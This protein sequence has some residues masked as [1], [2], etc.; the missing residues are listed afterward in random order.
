MLTLVFLA[1]AIAAGDWPNYGRDPGGSRFSPLDQIH[2]GNVQKLR[3]AWRFRHGDIY[4]GGPGRRSSL[5]QST[6]LFVDHRLFVTSPFGRVFALD[7]ETGKQLWVFDPE[8]DVAAGYGDFAN[9]GV[10]TWLDPE[11]RKG[12]PCKRRI[13]VATIDAR[14]FALDS[15]TGKPCA[16]F[17]QKGSIDLRTGLRNPSQKKSEYEQTSPPV[18]VGDVVVVGS[19]IADNTRIDLPSGEVRGFSARTGE[20]LWTWHSIPQSKDDP[21]YPEWEPES[22]KK[23]GG[24]NAW[25]IFTADPERG[26]VFVPT[27]SA[28]PDYFGGTR[29][30]DNRYANSVV[31]L[32]A[33]DGKMV[34]HFQTVHHDL[35][36]YDVASPPALFTLKKDGKSIPA[37]AVGSKTG[38]LFLLDRTTGAPVFPVEERKVPASDVPGE[39][40]SPTQPFPSMPKPLVP[41]SLRPDE[42]W[43]ATEEDRKWCAEQVSKR[44]S[45]GIFTPPSLRG[46]VIV[47][48]NIG[49]MAWGG[50][51]IDKRNGLLIVPTNRLAAVVRLIPR[52]RAEQARSE[53]RDAEFAPQHGTPYAMQRKFLRSPSGAP[54]NAPP[55]GTL[56]ALDANTGEK[57]WEV[58]LG[59]MPQAAAIPGAEKFGSPSLGG[60][61][62]TAG[63]LVFIGASFDPH[64]RAFDVKTGK[65]LWRG[66]LPA[67]A[68]A[69]PMTYRTKSGKQFVAIA[70]GGHGLPGTNPGDELTVFALP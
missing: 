1:A 30:G 70:A 40:S 64:L 15:A 27:G 5:F 44:R 65:E 69:T 62:V 10:S 20:L 3:V 33:K 37:I 29:K 22:A 8:V 48:G 57:R 46:S 63:G 60:P 50:T 58:P 45:E 34:W 55:W 42:V 25:S 31:A 43:G 21:A 19:A 56:A 26:L 66:E 49:G 11:L 68:R 12:E 52:E 6:P 38:H 4:R 51:A 54:C 16:A 35:W 39:A 59:V 13:F 36:D 53:D 67:S 14:L 23:T 47:P 9:R 7:P 32:R 2:T 17:A 28:S 18:V 61:I 24:A 41:Q